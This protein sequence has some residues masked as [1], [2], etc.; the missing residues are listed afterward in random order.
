MSLVSSSD[1]PSGADADV[2]A[3]DPNLA[4]K[5]SLIPVKRQLVRVASELQRL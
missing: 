4:K 3:V 2:G 1:E 5:D